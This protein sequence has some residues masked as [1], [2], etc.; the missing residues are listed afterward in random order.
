MNESPIDVF[1]KPDVLFTKINRSSSYKPLT[2]NNTQFDYSPENGKY[3]I[4]FTQPNDV[5]VKDFQKIMKAAFSKPS[6]YFFGLHAAGIQNPKPGVFIPDTLDQGID[7]TALIK[8]QQNNGS[9]G[10]ERADLIARIYREYGVLEQ[11]IP[12][13]IVT[14]HYCATNIGKN[15]KGEIISQ[16]SLYITQFELEKN[17]PSQNL[18]NVLNTMI[19]SFYYYQPLT[20]I[21]KKLID[22]GYPEAQ[23]NAKNAVI[24]GN[25]S[26]IYSEAFIQALY[27]KEQFSVLT[28]N[29]FIEK[30]VF[31][32]SNA[33]DTFTEVIELIKKT[34]ELK[35]SPITISNLWHVNRS[36]EFWNILLNQQQPIGK[37]EHEK[38]DNFIQNLKHSGAYALLQNFKNYSKN[39]A[40]KL[41]TLYGINPEEISFDGVDYL[42]DKDFLKGLYWLVSSN[43]DVVIG[44]TESITSIYDVQE[45]EKYEKMY[46]AEPMQ[47]RL[48][49]EW[50]SGLK[51]DGSKKDS[52]PEQI[53]KGTYYGGQG[54]LDEKG[55]FSLNK[56]KDVEIE[57]DF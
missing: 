3:P 26:S 22:F 9:G 36:R 49:N 16:P 13:L 8:N 7:K 38:K 31:L 34:G 48:K 33:T 30:N 37:N 42:K 23:M 15:E 27:E 28:K 18:P 5:E 17:I 56:Y 19:H 55:S 43:S 40:Q 45:A 47:H 25:L 20:D 39:Q 35:K 54:V 4:R 10:Q 11:Y 14:A 21:Q 44:I 32:E 50:A 52:A 2:S 1:Y 12:P 57:K 53:R 6:K 24:Q 29:D 41:A 46:E 51:P